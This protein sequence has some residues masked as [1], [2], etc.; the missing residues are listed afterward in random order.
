[1]KE[2]NTEKWAYEKIGI[3]FT[4]E[5]YEKLCSINLVAMDER[6]KYIPV[7][8]IIMTLKALGLIPTEQV[9]EISDSETTDNA[10]DIRKNELQQIVGVFEEQ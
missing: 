1:M 3:N 2:I 9:S 6:N 7:H 10:E 4:D 5:Q 8:F